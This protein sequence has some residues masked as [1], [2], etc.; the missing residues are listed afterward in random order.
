MGNYHYATFR[1]F[2]LVIILMLSCSVLSMVHQNKQKAERYYK[3]GHDL[4][5]SGYLFQAYDYY[6]EAI[7]FDRHHIKAYMNRGLV[8]KQLGYYW[9]AVDDFNRVILLSDDASHLHQAYHNRGVLFLR[10]DDRNRAC[11][12]FRKAMLSGSDHS[13]FPLFIYCN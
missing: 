10:L 13:L 11:R 1:I 8:A 3:R 2:A 7:Y 6:T 12:S 9:D 5:M 4:Q